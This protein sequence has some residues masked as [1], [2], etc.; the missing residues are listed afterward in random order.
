MEWF[1][2]NRISQNLMSGNKDAAAKN[3]TAALTEAAGNILG[4][5]EAR[6]QFSK[7]VRA[8]RDGHAQVIGSSESESSVVIISAKD[9]TE[10]V[11]EIIDSQP[12]IEFLMEIP[13]FQTGGSYDIPFSE[14]PR[15]REDIQSSFLLADAPE[16][17][18]EDELSNTNSFRI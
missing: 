9:L 7:I 8:A 15:S 6:D 5:R 10:L 18:L 17:D 2:L 1:Q 14:R 13:C 16:K 12:F 4:V 3:M 11:S